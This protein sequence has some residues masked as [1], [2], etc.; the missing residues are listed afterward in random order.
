[1]WESHLLSIKSKGQLTEKAGGLAG[2]AKRRALT[3][4][5]YF[6]PAWVSQAI[7]QQVGMATAS[8]TEYTVLD[9]S[10]GSGRLLMWAN[11]PAT[12]SLYG[13]DVDKEKVSLV[14]DAFT[15]AGFTTDFINAGMEDVSLGEYS[16]AVLNP[17]FSITL[18][19]PNLTPYD[20]ITTFGRFG[21]DTSALSHEYALQ[22]ALKH[23]G[24]VFAVLP[25]SQV[26][27]LDKYKGFNRLA[28]IFQL[29]DNAFQHEGVSQVKTSLCVF[30]SL[31][32]G[33]DVV[34]ATIQEG[35]TL[36]RLGLTVMAKPELKSPRIRRKGV[37]EDKPAIKLPVTGD[38]RVRLYAKSQDL[39]GIRFSCGR[40]QGLALNAILSSRLVSSS[41]HRYPQGIKYAGQ[42]KLNLQA[43]LFADDPLRS[44]EE[45][46]VEPLQALGA[47]VSID[48]QLVNRLR[49]LQKI[50]ARQSLP[51][52]KWIY[53][54]SVSEPAI[55]RV[56]S[57]VDLMD[58]S[59]PMVT[60]GGT[61]TVALGGDSHTFV[62][63]G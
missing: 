3:G 26:D 27:T 48:T 21:P 37:D 34:R 58:F 53:Q 6:T 1:M 41:E 31:P 42:G 63:D 43:H 36:P 2:I 11:D 29:P 61:Y 50:E 39:L 33:R 49:K 52:G 32:R 47:M 18:S 16:V 30:D 57:P 12:F 24:V 38:N 59:S 60:K 19:S 14:G 46:L 54:Q 8:D 28:A 51:F 5:Q 10:M 17:P 4:S 44:L 62:I 22:Q 9:N 20:G 55:A 13:L 15:E 7:G 40:M 23:A 56:N 35:D 45:T 25:Q